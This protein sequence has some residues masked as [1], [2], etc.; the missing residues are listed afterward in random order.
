MKHRSESNV[1]IFAGITDMISTAEK[2]SSIYATLDPV[3]STVKAELHKICASRPSLQV[4]VAPPMYRPRPVWYNENM[5]WVANQFSSCLTDGAP[6]NLHLLPSHIA[7]DL[8]PDGVHLTPVAGLHYVLF[9]FDQSADNLALLQTSSEQ[10]FMVARES[11]RALD[12]RVSYLEHDHSRLRHEAARKSAIDAEFD[13]W[14]RNRSEEDWLTIMG[15]PRLSSDL[16]GRSWQVEV[17]RQVRD[18]IN[19]ILKVNRVNLSFDVLYVGNPVRG[20]TSGPT[21]YNVQLNSAQVSKRIRETYSGFFR[22]RNPVKR[23]SS[24]NGVS[25][26]NKITLDTKIRLAILRQLGERYLVNNPGGHYKVQGFKPRPFLVIQPPS[27]SPNARVRSFSYIEAISSLPT[28]FSDEELTQIFMIVGDH[29]RGKLR[30]LFVVLNDEDHDRCLDL[31]KKFHQE[32]R[33]G[34]GARPAAVSMAQSHVSSFSGP[35]SGMEVQAGLLAALRQPPPPPPVSFASLQA[36]HKDKGSGRTGRTARTKAFKRS[37][38]SSSGERRKR[39]QRGKPSKRSR[40]LP[41]SSSSSSSSSGSSSDSS[42]SSG[43][44]SDSGSGSGSSSD[45]RS[46]PVSK[47]M[48]KKKK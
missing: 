20:R 22:G 33:T 38:R 11:I 35:G 26:R 16:D 3:L 47:P 21:V 13:D 23:P 9:L 28:H 24:L 46:K 18:A 15:L 25:L 31:V 36:K 41:S 34:K 37:R 10:Q 7:Q 30:Q 12:D 6:S 39:S 14:I 48:L 40:R 43:S 17:K 45:S 5:P 32:R 4:M 2:R 42:S 29:D 1:C 44:E 27:G 8:G 19:L